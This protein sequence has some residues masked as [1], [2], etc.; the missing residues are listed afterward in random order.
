MAL[1]RKYLSALGIEAEK[2]DE[3]IAAHAET[4][5]ALKEEAEK[6]AAAAEKLKATEKE[7][8]DLK[9]ETEG[10]ETIKKDFE[11]YKKGVEE[12]EARRAKETAYREALKDSNLSD[13]GIEKAI[14]YAEWDKVTVGEDGKLANA[15]E[16]VKEAR[17]E[18]AEYIVKTQTRG[19]QTS[20]PPAGG[21]GSVLTREDIYKKDEHGRYVMD[22]AQ[23]QKAWAE[24]LRKET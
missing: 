8:A 13:K 11:D 14:K 16:L 15:K 5:N 18:W 20:T 2:I 12:K 7:L 6:N 10:Y 21:S 22:A 24:V 3:I 4:V 23:R 17:E 9:K 1:T 19:A